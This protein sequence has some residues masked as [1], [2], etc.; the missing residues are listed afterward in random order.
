MTILWLTD[1]HNVWCWGIEPAMRRFEVL[2]PGAVQV[3]I[4]QGG[5]FED[6]RP[7]REQWA[8]M[9]GGRWK[10]SILAF[11]D[12]VST[13]HRM[14]MDGDRMLEESDDFDSTWP[15]CLAAKAADLQGEEAGRRYLRALR[16][17]WYLD[18]R[19]I[20]RPTVQRAI[21]QEIG[22]DGEAFAAALEDGR[23]ERAFAAD[24]EIA[25]AAGIT[26]FPSFEIDCGS[27]HARIE[28]WQPW[29]AFDEVVRKLAPDL[30]AR[31][32]APTTATVRDLL[33][34]YPRCA[35]REIGA[36]LGVPDDDAEILLEDLEASGDVSRRPVGKGLIWQPSAVSAATSEAGEQSAP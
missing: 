15:A 28:G 9:S 32:L 21:A 26:G 24:R 12:A 1:P 30:V 23:A 6:F 7:V 17:G 34:R 18:G 5:L 29:E 8:R 27:E 36:I 31:E 4:V 19:G 22:L 3:R 33:R 13:Q 35:T 25:R 10:D 2:Y 20:H 11:F 16:E 14:P